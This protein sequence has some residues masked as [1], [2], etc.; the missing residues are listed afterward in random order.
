MYVCIYFNI[1]VGSAVI[2]CFS[3]AETLPWLSTYLDNTCYSNNARS[4]DRY[5]IC[6]HLLIFC[7]LRFYW[8]ISPQITDDNK[9]V[10]CKQQ[11]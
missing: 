10:I 1:F 7:F 8:V 9:R 11:V 2:G 4:F 3:V 6:Y 5:K